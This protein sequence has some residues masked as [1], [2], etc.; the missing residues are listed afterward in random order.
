MALTTDQPSNARRLRRP[1]NEVQGLLLEAAHRLFTTQ[2]YHGTTTR[3]IAEEAGVGESVLFRAFGSKAE[4]FEAAILTPFTAFVDQWAA[5]WDARATSASDPEE[6]TQS[7]VKGFYGLAA[8]HKELIQTLI[9]A[10]VKGGDRALA[11]VADRVSAKLADSLRVIQR[12]LLEQGAARHLRDVDAPVSVAFSVG[13]VLSLVLLD[14]WVFP[15]HQRRP[16]KARQID[17]ATR[18]L[19]YGVTGAAEIQ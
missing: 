12:V 4:L 11:E 13:S 14:D 5:K 10:R 1:P 19:L 7:F 3:Q 15:A 9:A 17:E 6:I 18:M 8:D 2:G 16:G